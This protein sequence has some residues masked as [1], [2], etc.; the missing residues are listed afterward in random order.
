MSN[1]ANREPMIRASLVPR[2]PMPERLRM[3]LLAFL[4]LFV[5]LALIRRIGA[6]IVYPRGQRCCTPH[7]SPPCS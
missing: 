1:V 3:L 2:F 7:S 5:E 6:N 4:V